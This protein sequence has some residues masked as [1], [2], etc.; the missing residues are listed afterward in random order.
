[1]KDILVYVGLLWM[2]TTL[3]A[4]DDVVSLD[5][6]NLR[7]NMMVIFLVNTLL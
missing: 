6:K 1:M 7:K 5:I 2:N 4:S 3:V